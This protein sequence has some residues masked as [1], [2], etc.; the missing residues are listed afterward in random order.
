MFSFPFDVTA[1]PNNGI[2]FPY[3]EGETSGHHGRGPRIVRVGTHRDG[4]FRSRIAQHFL[5][6]EGKMAFTRDRPKPSDRSIFRKHIGRALLNRARDPYLSIWE[7]DFTERKARDAKGRLRDIN[8]E[9]A[10]EK[11]VTAL[12][13]QK[14]SFRYIEI[15]DEMQRMGNEG[16]EKALI[17]TLASCPQCKP[18]EG[19]LGRYHPDRR[20]RESG[21]WLIHHLSA[22]PLTSAQTSLITAAIE[23]AARVERR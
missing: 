6:D 10:L 2:Y 14:F 17:G 11:E 16:L 20:V 1:L 4:N 23:E 3:E 22:V 15:A 18:S 7:I 21:M 12:L 19:W 8:K 5:L 13:R 9:A